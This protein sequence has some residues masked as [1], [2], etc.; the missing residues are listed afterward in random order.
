VQLP[1]KL[2]PLLLI[3]ALATFGL[4]CEPNIDIT[5]ENPTNEDVLI[6]VNDGGFVTIEARSEDTFTFLT[7]NVDQFDI[8]VMTEDGEVIFHEVLTEKELEE[9]GNRT[10]VQEPS[11]HRPTVPRGV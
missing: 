10:T 3:S 7:D 8:T 6:E 1:K 2:L 4:A 5:F 11:S 9:R